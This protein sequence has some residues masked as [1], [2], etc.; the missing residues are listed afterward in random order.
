M[1]RKNSL[2]NI[3]FSMIIVYGFLAI[4]ALTMV[5]P[6]VHEWAKSFSYPTEAMAGRVAFW[7]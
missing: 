1:A 6:F 5:L 4:V 7:P 2:K 3:T